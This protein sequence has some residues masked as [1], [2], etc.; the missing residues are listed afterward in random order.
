MRC[1][2]MN[3]LLRVY[4]DVWWLQ[5][6]RL[7]YWLTRFDYNR[8]QTEL[9]KSIPSSNPTGSNKDEVSNQLRDLINETEKMLNERKVHAHD[10]KKMADRDDIGRD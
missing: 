6:S 10:A 8:L 4:R 3:P 2:I 7:E 1:F 9:E 5:L